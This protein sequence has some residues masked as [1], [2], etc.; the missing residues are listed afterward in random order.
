MK[1]ALLALLLLGAATESEAQF[2]IRRNPAA[3]NQ[4]QIL[5]KVPSAATV[6]LASGTH[7]VQY[8][9]FALQIPNTQNGQNISATFTPGAPLASLIAFNTVTGTD[10]GKKTFVFKSAGGQPNYGNVYNFG[11]P[12][13]ESVLGIV[14]FTASVGNVANAIVVAIDYQDQPTYGGPGTQDAVWTMQLDPTQLEV[15][16]YNSLFYQS[17]ASGSSPGSNAPT[18]INEGGV[19]NQSVAINS[20]PLNV[21]LLTFNAAATSDRTTKLEW[22]TATETN[23]SHFIVERSLTGQRF[24]EVVA[25]MEAAGTSK[26]MLNYHTLDLNPIT[27]ANYYRLKMFSKDGTYKYS[28]TRKVVFDAPPADVVVLPNPFQSATTVRITAGQAQVANYY[29]MDAAGR[30]IRSGVWELTKGT[31]EFPL[32]L[33]DAAAGTYLL[34]VQGS[35]ILSELKLVKTN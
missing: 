14:N 24:N 25:R 18:T 34:T 26:D 35:T 16:Q 30:T 19:N 8:F 20:T 21:E 10:Y 1:Q 28:E 32:P 33:N 12:G 4:V 13:T 6:P 11:L 17:A 27:G 3:A 5:Y 15:T 7:S 31:Q 9:Q 29:V 22:A 2:S 23:S